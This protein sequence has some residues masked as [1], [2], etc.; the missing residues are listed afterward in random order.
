MKITNLLKSPLNNPV[1]YSCAMKILGSGNNKIKFINEHVKPS[2]GNKILDF[3]CGPANILEYLPEDIVYTGVDFNEKCI[4]SAQKKYGSRG[5]F[6]LGDVSEE[7]NN[8]FI[9]QYDIVLAQGLIHH[10]SDADAIF[11]IS[12]AYECLKDNGRFI[13]LDNVYDKNINIIN[14][15]AL[16]LDRGEYIRSKREYLDLFSQFPEVKCDVVKSKLRI[17]YYHI[18]CQVKK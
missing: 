15:I 6:I 3:G 11:L 12:N 1:I 5:T 18:I 17:P 14:K 7:K 16:K 2:S 13:T 10:L 8:P 4:E 9:G